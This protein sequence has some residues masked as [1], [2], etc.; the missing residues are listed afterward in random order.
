MVNHMGTI[1]TKVPLDLDKYDSLILEEND[2]CFVSD[3][4]SIKIDQ[5]I[6]GEKPLPKTIDVVNSETIS[7]ANQADYKR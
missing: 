6:K 1:I 3:S 4:N 2:F 5:F 7:S